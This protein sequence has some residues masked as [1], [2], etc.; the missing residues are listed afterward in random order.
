[1]LEYNKSLLIACEF[2]C[3]PACLLLIFDRRGI[4]I[5][6]LEKLDI[7]S[8][9]QFYLGSYLNCKIPEE[10][11]KYFEPY[12]DILKF[13]I[14]HE[15]RTNGC[16]VNDLNKQLFKPLNIPLEEQFLS[17]RFMNDWDLLTDTIKDNLKAG[18]DLMVF[19]DYAYLTNDK[20]NSPRGHCLLISD[21]DEEKNE[22]TIVNPITER[23]V[24]EDK[25]P[26]DTVFENSMENFGS[27]GGISIIKTKTDKD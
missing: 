6:E 3:V 19:L 10:Q 15:K 20:V 22:I 5:E 9:R 2:M 1:M 12:K 4:K 21:Y 27:S 26:L 18:N 17:A 23:E 14:S 11:L 25:Y 8:E 24:I 7:D 16:C 13:D